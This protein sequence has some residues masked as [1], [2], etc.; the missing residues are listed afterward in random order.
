MPLS[1]RLGR[2]QPLSKPT[3]QRL[4]RAWQAFPVSVGMNIL[5]ETS[6]CPPNTGRKDPKSKEKGDL[7]LNAT[8]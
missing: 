1:F 7:A 6:E 5:E 3:S 2:F 8:Q 4:L